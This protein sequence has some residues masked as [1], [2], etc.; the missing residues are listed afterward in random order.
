MFPFPDAL[1]CF[2]ERNGPYS[3]LLD[4]SGVNAAAQCI[5]PPLFLNAE[6]AR[7]MVA[8]EENSWQRSGKPATF[9]LFFLVVLAR[10]QMPD[11]IIADAELAIQFFRHIDI[12]DKLHQNVDAFFV[13]AD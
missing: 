9:P 12:G 13:L 2:Q 1:S 10:N 3:L 8:Y 6:R 11:H 7:K 4:D 5:T